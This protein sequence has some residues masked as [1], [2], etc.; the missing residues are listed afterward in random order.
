VKILTG[1]APAI[2][3]KVAREIG[4]L[5]PHGDIG[6]DVLS[7]TELAA[8]S[9]SLDRSQLIERVRKA[10]IFAKVS[11]YQKRQVIELLKEGGEK[12]AMLGD[13]VNDALALQA[14]D[15]GISVDTGT[16]IAKEASDIIL[17]E[18]SLSVVTHGR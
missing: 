13:G 3:V 4:L 11:P 1:D 7:G 6:T 15:V 8:I 16:E 18:K 5:K 12:V 2:A 14:A 17:L 10:V 9:A